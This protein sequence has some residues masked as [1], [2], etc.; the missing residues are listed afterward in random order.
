MLF[1]DVDFRPE[2]LMP[3]KCPRHFSYHCE[4]EQAND[5]T[6][7]NNAHVVTV[8]GA[9]LAASNSSGGAFNVTY[10][11]GVTV[12][13]NSHDQSTSIAAAAALAAAA[14]VTIIVLGDR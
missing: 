8:L 10:A 3:S 14:D 6:L 1:P 5:A 4:Q 2:A 12:I 13:T 9:A 11:A 7:D